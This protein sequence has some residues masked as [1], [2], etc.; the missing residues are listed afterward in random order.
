MDALD[1]YRRQARILESIETRHL[2]RNIPMEVRVVMSEYLSYFKGIDEMSASDLDSFVFN[3]VVE[4]HD[5]EIKTAPHAYN[6]Y[7]KIMLSDEEL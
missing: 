2:Q 4:L 1:R 7:Q 5:A 6:Y 3:E